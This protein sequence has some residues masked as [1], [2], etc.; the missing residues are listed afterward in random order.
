MC[1]GCRDKV[2]MSD[3]DNKKHAVTA[4]II[5]HRAMSLK[6]SSSCWDFSGYIGIAREI[7]RTDIVEQKRIMTSEVRS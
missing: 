4:K 1:Q 3:R 6:L 7:R 2:R 5:S